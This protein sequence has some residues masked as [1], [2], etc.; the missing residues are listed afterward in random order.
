LCVRFGSEDLREPI[1][2]DNLLDDDILREHLQKNRLVEWFQAACRAGKKSYEESM[3]LEKQQHV[4]GVRP[5]GAASHGNGSEI[6]P[7]ADDVPES[8][9]SDAFEGDVESAADQDQDVE[10]QDS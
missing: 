2:K 8:A 6:A 4:S 10:M 9:G 5:D 7:E 3:R 1:I